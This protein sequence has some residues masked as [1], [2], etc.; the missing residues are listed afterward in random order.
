MKTENKNYT[1]L[2]EDVI[3]IISQPGE[4]ATDGEC[5]DEVMK[6]FNIKHE[7]LR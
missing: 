3:K 6:L 2:R 7:D 5:L 4:E 1:E